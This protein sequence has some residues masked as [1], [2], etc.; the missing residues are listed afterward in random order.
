MHMSPEG[1]R[2]EKDCAGN[3]QKQLKTTDATS[4]QAG[5]PTSTSP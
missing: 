4:R 1:L 2:P 3:A 5:R